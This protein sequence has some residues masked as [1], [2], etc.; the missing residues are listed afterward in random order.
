MIDPTRHRQLEEL[1]M[2]NLCTQILHDSRNELY[3][4]MHFLDIS[5]SSLKLEA[6][7]LLKG[8]GT[9]GYTIYYNPDNLCVLYRK[10]RVY[11]NRAYLHMVLHCLFCHL[12]TRGKRE[13]EYWNLACDI[14]MESI[15]DGLYKKCVH[16]APTPFR[17]ET[18]LRFGRKLKVFT[19]EG[20]YEVLQDMN[21]TREQYNRLAAEFYVDS[22]EKWDEDLPPGM[23][24]PVPRQDR[25]KDNREKLQTEMESGGQDI[26]RTEEEKSLLEHVQVENRERYDYK[27]FLRR[28][29]VMKEEM[30]MDDDSF[31]YIYYTYG[32]NKYGNM[33]LIEPLESKEVYRIEDFVLVIDTS[34]S[35]SGQLVR[36]F[37]EETYGVLRESES[38]FRKINV[39]IIQCDDQVR[40]DAVIRSQE[41]ME[42]YM[43]DFAV[44][45]SGGTDFRPAF[46]YVEHLR[47]QGEFT[48]L[49]GLLYFT[50]GKGIYPVKMPPFDTAF[51]FVQDQY[52]D[53]SVPTW[54][55]KLILEREHWRDEGGNKN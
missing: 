29:A 7:P 3:L 30:Q 31:D 48:R 13:R 1:N 53:V 38:Y 28:F 35:C 36:R 46:E 22:H 44:T 20:I 19:A 11:V 5:L 25:W 23:P 34:M 40:S 41:E 10:G 37:L 43:K 49:R 24:M 4:N 55:I 32:L 47:K 21:L 6:D 12:D 15:I 51:V 54:A 52:E 2:V 17:R 26:S 16:A 45:G 14:A 9:D 42:D 18:Y 39:H 27:R 50:D 8:V 33:P